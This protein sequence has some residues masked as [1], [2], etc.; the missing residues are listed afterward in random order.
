V[1]SGGRARGS[2]YQT[3]SLSRGRPRRDT[4]HAAPK[5]KR[6]RSMNSSPRSSLGRLP[7]DFEGTNSQRPAVLRRQVR[8]IPRV[9]ER[10][11]PPPKRPGDRRRVPVLAVR[12][13][14]LSLRFRLTRSRISRSARPSIDRQAAPSVT[15]WMSATTLF[16]RQRA[17]LAVIERQ[18]VLDAPNTLE[19]P[20]R[21]VPSSHR[22]EVEEGP[23]IGGR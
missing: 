13:D 21:D 3:A 1:T 22:S 16:R 20:L 9:A 8:A 2:C 14:V 17:E 15:Q 4:P 5:N 23:A 6:L 7:E 19:V 18:L 10:F 11:P 12:V